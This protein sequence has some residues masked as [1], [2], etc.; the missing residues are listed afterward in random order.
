ME[1]LQVTTLF[2]MKSSELI[3]DGKDILY[4]IANE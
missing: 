1:K 4:Q 2:C 3:S